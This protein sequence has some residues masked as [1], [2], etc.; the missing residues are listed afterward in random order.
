MKLGAS[1]C[2]VFV[3]VVACGCHK[4]ESVSERVD[5][6]TYL[7]SR[8]PS[9]ED[10]CAKGE[11]GYCEVLGDFYHFGAA[12]AAVDEVKSKAFY[13]RACAG[14]SATACKKEQ[15]P[16]WLAKSVGSR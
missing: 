4:S 6:N 9:Y 2:L 7:T 13:H 16:D 3:V 10:A 12:G 1:L 11:I 15:D 14:G 5:P 8:K